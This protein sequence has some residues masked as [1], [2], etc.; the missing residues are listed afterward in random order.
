MSSEDLSS[1]INLQDYVFADFVNDRAEEYFNRMINLGILRR[2]VDGQG[3][4]S[5]VRL[6]PLGR[7][8]ISTVQNEVQRAG[9]RKKLQKLLD[10]I[11]FF[12]KK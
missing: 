4:T 2:E 5:R 9:I 6:T 8:A 11:K 1:K 3:L 10:A 7:Q 12:N